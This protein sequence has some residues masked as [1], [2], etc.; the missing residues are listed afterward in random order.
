MK[1]TVVLAALRFR[2]HKR[3][4]FSA[5]S[6]KLFVCGGI[7]LFVEIHWSVISFILWK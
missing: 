1:R 2:Q 3:K 7:F 4:S 5:L 6:E